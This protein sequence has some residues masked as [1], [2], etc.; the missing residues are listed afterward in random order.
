MFKNLRNKFILT[1]MITATIIILIAFSSIFIATAASHRT[2]VDM[3]RDS[4]LSDEMHDRFAE[5]IQND[6]EERLANLGITLITV[7]MIIEL[8]VFGIS[9]YL[10]DKAIRPVQDAYRKQKEFIANA[11]HELKTP[12]AAARANFEALGTTEQ[13]WTDNVDAELDR[14]A[15]LVNSMLTLA[16][17]DGRVATAKRK[18]IDL[19]KTVTKRAQLI[20]ARLGE[21]ELKVVAPEEVKKVIAEFEAMESKEY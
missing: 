20:N 6:R 11:S 7:G 8:L 10:A 18:E 14:A 3:R 17:T 12:I 4:S 19:V 16:R 5:E 2:P 1:N 13:P 21:K 9:Y 15:E